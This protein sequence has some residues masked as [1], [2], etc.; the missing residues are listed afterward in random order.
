MNQKEAVADVTMMIG[1]LEILGFWSS[2]NRGN[3]RCR[4]QTPYES[5]MTC[6]EL[7]PPALGNLID[8]T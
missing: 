7:Y 5:P 1:R 4:E 3:H 8:R 6:P 2:G